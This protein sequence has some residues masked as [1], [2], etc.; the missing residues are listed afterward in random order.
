ML[1]NFIYNHEYLR[2]NLFKKEFI[3]GEFTGLDTR[4]I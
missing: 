1:Y 3:Q 2:F 4:T